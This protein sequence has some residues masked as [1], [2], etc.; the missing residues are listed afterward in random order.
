MSR[1]KDTV[2][3]I[4]NG[5]GDLLDALN[6]LKGNM[7]GISNLGNDDNTEALKEVIDDIV[8][9]FKCNSIMKKT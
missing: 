8:I 1:A 5:T 9:N 7:S 6:K 2:N 3:E 4:F